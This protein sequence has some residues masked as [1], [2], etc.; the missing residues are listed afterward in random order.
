MAFGITALEVSRTSLGEDA[1]VVRSMRDAPTRAAHSAAPPEASVA[2]TRKEATHARDEVAWDADFRAWVQAKYRYLLEDLGVRHPARGQLMQLLLSWE[3]AAGTLD[4]RARASDSTLL[5]I[6]RE[7][8]ALL[9][10]EHYATFERLRNSE[11]E[12]HQLLEFTGGVSEVARLTPTQERAIL[13]SQLRYKQAFEAAL[14]ESGFHRDTLSAAEREYAHK[15]VREALNAYRTGF[16]RDARASLNEDQYQLLSDY[17]QTE[18]DHE[19]GALQIAIN[20][21]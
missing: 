21:K 11:E 3:S 10:A 6:E 13:E 8:R 19:L 14:A 5:A 20:S 15:A 1:I 16:L 9:P 17:E 18:I 7:L 12:Q 4:Q 2:A